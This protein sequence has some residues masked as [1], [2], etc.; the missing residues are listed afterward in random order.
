MDF[1]L[2]YI[3]EFLF[4]GLIFYDYIYFI[5]LNMVYGILIIGLWVS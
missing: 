4:L 5:E 3:I 1:I 2:G